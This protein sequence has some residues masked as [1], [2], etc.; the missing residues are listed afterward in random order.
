MVLFPSPYYSFD[1]YEMVSFHLS[2]TSK[3]S[4]M[5]S[6]SKSHITQEPSVEH[7]LSSCSPNLWGG[8]SHLRT[9]FQDPSSLRH[10]KG[11]P[12][13]H[14]R[15]KASCAH[16]PKGPGCPNTSSWEPTLCWSQQPF[17]GLSSFGEEN[18]APGFL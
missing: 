6:F 7:W 5:H 18:K 12:A 4:D 8:L 13:W 9:P 16:L 11:P 14:P 1:N 3:F 2:S 15:E 10:I 17:L